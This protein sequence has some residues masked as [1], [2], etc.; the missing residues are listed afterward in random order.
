MTL[1]VFVVVAGCLAFIIALAFRKYGCVWVTL[2]FPLL[3]VVWLF[4]ANQAPNPETEFVRLF[5]SEGR[6]SVT[7]LE[8]IKPTMMD[9]YLIKFQ[10]DHDAFT[11]VL[12]SRFTTE[13]LGG[14]KFFRS[15]SRPSSWP[16]YLEH[17]DES[18]RCDIGKDVLLAYYEESSQTFYGS[19]HYDSW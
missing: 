12:D 6:S 2:P 17:L 19:F 3:M 10:I 14:R 7:N 16:P 18:L 1:I 8:T 9:G 11:R 4:F 5:G 15:G 13:L